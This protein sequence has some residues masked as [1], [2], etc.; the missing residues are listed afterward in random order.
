MKNRVIISCVAIAAILYFVFYT[1]TKEQF[2][3][4]LGDVKALAAKSLLAPGTVVIDAPA[5]QAS[6]MQASTP[7]QASSPMQQN[8]SDNSEIKRDKST[9]QKI[10]CP[11]GYQVE[12]DGKKHSCVADSK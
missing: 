1:D 4:F 5:V 3:D 7:M 2:Y 6:T 9:K 8:S 12:W 11:P 10:E